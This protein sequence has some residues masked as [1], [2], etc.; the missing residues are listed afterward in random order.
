[1][2][3]TSFIY[4]QTEKE[5]SEKKVQAAQKE[6]LELKKAFDGD[7]CGWCEKK[8]GS[9]K[10]YFENAETGEVVYDKPVL[11]RIAEAMANVQAGQDIAKYKKQVEDTKTQL[12]QQQVRT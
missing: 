5:V 8:D 4:V 6:L 2:V 7:T 1:M 3:L 12:R 10:A 9:N 11:M